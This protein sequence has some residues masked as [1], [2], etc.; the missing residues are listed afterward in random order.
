MYRKWRLPVTVCVNTGAFA[1]WVRQT[2]QYFSQLILGYY[3]LTCCWTERKIKW[4]GMQQG[5][6][7]IYMY[8]FGKLQQMPRNKGSNIYRG[9]FRMK[10][11]K[12]TTAPYT[13]SLLYIYW[14]QRSTLPI[15]LRHYQKQHL[16]LCCIKNI[17]CNNIQCTQRTLLKV[18]L[19][20]NDLFL[21][22]PAAAFIP[23]LNVLA[24]R[25]A[26]VG[27]YKKYIVE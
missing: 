13:S 26:A 19:E 27:P 5:V 11:A 1:Y 2:A 21:Y 9:L 25:D 23:S 24:S 4:V 10:E 20:L 15:H 18:S 17:V 3:R 14:P 22:G 8:L 12:C 6:F 16:T 7:A